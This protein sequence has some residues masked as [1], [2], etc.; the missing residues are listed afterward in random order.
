MEGWCSACVA[1][2]V[3]RYQGSERARRAG[4]TCRFDPSCSTY[5]LEALA[6]RRLPAA[7]ATIAGRVLR[8]N[9]LARRVTRDPLA[10]PHPHR[11]RPNAVPTLA[12]VVALTSTVVLLTAGSAAS[13]DITGGCTGTI[14]GRDAATVTR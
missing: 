1:A 3:R 11:P 10:R 2:L 8:C 7:L 5:A 4:G 13:D 9:P 12:A 14:N 6:T